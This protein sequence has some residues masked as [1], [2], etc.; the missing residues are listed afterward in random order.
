MTDTGL[1]AIAEKFDTPAYV[2]DI[3]ALSERMRSVRDIVG[4][5]VGLCYSI[6]ANPFLIPAMLGLVDKLEVCSPGELEV[7]K[8]LNVP[9]EKIIYSGVVKTE[10]NVL[11]AAQYRVGTF[12][13]ESKKHVRLINEQGLRDGVRYRVLL[14]LNGG[15]QFG[16]SEE[17]IQSILEDIGNLKGIIIEGIHYFVGTGRGKLKQQQKEL[18]M[19][20]EFMGRVAGILAEAYGDAESGGG[21][22]FDGVDF[23]G[24][25]FDGTARKLCKL[26]YGPGLP[27]PYFEGDSFED[28]LA[29]LKELAPALKEIAKKTELTIEMGRFFASECGYYLSRVMDIKSANGINYCLIDGGIN[30]INYYGQ[31]MGMKVPVIKHF[32]GGKT[33]D[34]ETATG[35]AIAGERM[36]YA[37]AGSLCTT[38]DIP[39]REIE[40][41][42]LSEGD[43]L[44]FCNIGAY[45]VT[46]GLYMF[47]SRNM[48][49]ILLYEKGNTRMVREALHTSEF[50]TGRFDG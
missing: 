22:A 23:G 27:F 32:P 33:A 42:G 6:K 34:G 14:R 49:A 37:I 19:L 20:E 30:H 50:N 35:T 36:K 40:F 46:E 12:T 29:P 5:T 10:E 17:D 9:P 48:P 26:E 38:A 1:K 44:V 21:E 47:L 16:M 3:D 28:T 25:A 18:A 8:K 7:C 15:S 24:A 2:F 45:S 13:A 39:V 41:N 43:L 11:E 4:D 31:I